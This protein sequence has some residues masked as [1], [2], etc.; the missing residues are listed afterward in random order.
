MEPSLCYARIVADFSCPRNLVL[1]YNERF[2]HILIVLYLLHNHYSLYYELIMVSSLYVRFW[3]HTC[4]IL[5]EIFVV[6]QCGLECSHF[7][8][9]LYTTCYFYCLPLIVVFPSYKSVYCFVLFR[10]RKTH[11]TGAM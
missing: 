4:W 6:I 11:T 7:Y 9:I 3:D 1:A 10:A 5:R 8:S 2:I